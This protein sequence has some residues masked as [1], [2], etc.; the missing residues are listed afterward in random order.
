VIL[1]DSH[2]HLD[3]PGLVERVDEVLERARQ[4]GVALVVTI[5]T[6]RAGWET[7]I[8]LA[9]EHAGVVCALGVHPHNASKEGLDDP[10]PLIEAAAHPK[11]VAVGEAGLDYHYDVSMPEDQKRNFRAHIEAARET[12]LPLVVHTREADADTLAILQ[13]EYAKGPFS[14]EIHCFTGSRLLAEGALELGF[15][16]GIG[17]VLTFRRSDAMREVVTRLPAGRLLLE[18]DAPYLAPV[19]HRGRT[20][21]PAYLVETA[22]VLARVRGLDLAAVARITTANFLRLFAKAAPVL[23][24]AVASCG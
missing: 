11:V 20:N 7:A 14:G 12:G 6:T 1:V 4:A 16:F 9:E 15:L 22:K 23:D 10:A 13:E 24:A 18:T 2:C 5:A 3:F 8:R 19:P 17:G 21:E